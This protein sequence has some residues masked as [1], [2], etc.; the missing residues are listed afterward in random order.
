[1]AWDNVNAVP[2]EELLGAV[3]IGTDR[4]NPNNVGVIPIR[5][6]R[7]AIA[8]PRTLPLA[9]GATHG[10]AIPANGAH[11]RAFIDIPEGADTLMVSATGANADQN[12]GLGI[13]LVRMEFGSVF[14][15]VPFAEDAPGGAP[16]A[17]AS[18]SGG[19]GPVAM[20]SG[21]QLQPGRWYTVVRNSNGTPSSVELRADVGYSGEPVQIRGGLWQPPAGTPRQGINQG[22]EYSPAGIARGMVW[23]TYREDNSPAWYLAADL[24]SEGNVW[25]ADLLRFTN[26]GAEQQGVKVGKVIITMLGEEEMIFSYTLFGESGSEPM[27]PTAENSC[28]M[29]DGVP[30]SVIG[31]WFRG[32]DGLGGASVLYNAKGEHVQAHYVYDLF[33]NPRWLFAFLPE[34]ND[35][36]LHQF[37]GFCAVCPQGMPTFE[38]AGVLTHGF[39]SEDI[40]S[41]TQNY[42]FMPPLS[43]NANRTEDISKITDDLVCE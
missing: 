40:G 42:M 36:T 26:N 12:N 6:T 5:F 38:A 15:E 35:L 31:L 30:R 22:L 8:D 37:S 11:D 24:V 10:L 23:Y 4:E 20:L 16:A 28:P 14:G 25:T 17:S 19:N 27:V 7:T 21:A 41:W 13:D 43:G 33:G 18:G 32:I 9:D 39:T 29:I 34:G 3:G 1:V 2:G